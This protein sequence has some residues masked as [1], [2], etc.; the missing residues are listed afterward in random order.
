VQTLL[1]DQVWVH[2]G[3]LYVGS[4]G[5]EF[6]G[7]PECFGGQRNGLCGAAD[8]GL[9]FLITGLHTG[10]VA[11]AVELHDEPP[12]VDD[13]W[14][15]VVEV[16]F[17][18]MGGEASLIGWAGEWTQPLGLAEADYRVRYCGTGMDEGCSM[19]TRMPDDQVVERHLLQ[20]WPA[21]PAPDRIVRQGSAIAAYWHDFA[22]RQPAPPTPEE[23]LAARERAER[24]RAESA[25]RS[26]REAELRT[27]GGRLPSDRLRA[28]GGVALPLATLDRPLV[29]ALAEADPAA[30]R[31]I[32]RWVVRRAFV[33]AGLARVGWIAPALAALDRGEPLPPPFDDD[34]RAWE[35]LLSDPDV[36]STTVTSPDG[37]L[38]N[39]LQQAMAFPA[40][41][42]AVEPDPL[43][44]A[45]SALWS[46]AATFGQGR[47]TVLFTELRQTFPALA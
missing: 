9:L 30:L 25:R 15:D 43:L 22:S 35:L 45:V 16:S 8:P 11:F 19:D 20:F 12:P 42:Q 7:L 47:H 32:T 29:D 18:P 14:E 24:E 41:M 4:G 36:P 34:G 3:Q 26:R 39:C 31:E 21:P 27:W 5:G 40:L 1:N 6:A 28:L 46:A 10:E 37:W 13:G 17:R 2:Y 33:E 23:R 38:D 44:A